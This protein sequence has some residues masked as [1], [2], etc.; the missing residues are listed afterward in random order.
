MDW[1]HLLAYITG[2]VDQELLLRNEYLVTENRILRNQITGRMRLT[3]G[4]R[5]ILADIGY[6]L[7][8]QALAA[9]ATI[10][11]PDTILAWRRKLVASKFDGSQQRQAPGRPK[12]DQ[13]LEALIV[14]IARENRSWS[15]DRIVG[16]LANLGLTVSAQTV[17]NVLKRHGIAPAPERKTTT[18]WKEFIRTHTDVLVATDFFTAEVWTLGGLVTYY[19]LFFIHLGSRQVHVSGVTPHP[20]EAWMVQVARNATMEEWGFLSPGQY[21]I[22]DRDTKFCAAFH[23][24]IAAAVVT[25]VPLPPRSLNLN[26]YAERWVRSIKEECLSRLIL[27]GEASLRHALTQ[28]EAHFHHEQNHQ[29]KDNVLLFP[30]GS[31]DAERAGPIQCRERLGGLLKYYTCEAA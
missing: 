8:Q 24:I 13:E 19:I 29:G 31:P 27:F 2:T 28:Y 22:H 15:Y 18:T 5:K 12:I 11:K 17:G 25:R 21:L 3:D 4:E 1:K 9:V 16:A 26:A 30:T 6:K 14:R 20:N 7:G 10:V 23:Q